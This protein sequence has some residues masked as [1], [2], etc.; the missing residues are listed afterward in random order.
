MIAIIFA[1][2]QP[3]RDTF[4]VEEE[5]TP[6]DTFAEFAPKPTASNAAAATPAMAPITTVAFA[7]ESALL[8]TYC[9]G[10]TVPNWVGDHHAH[11]VGICSSYLKAKG[12]RTSTAKMFDCPAESSSVNPRPCMSICLGAWASHQSQRSR[13]QQ[14]TCTY[15][16]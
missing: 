15:C 7:L 2:V 14:P 3:S 12:K 8:A 1:T 13:V 5:G 11:G 16:V 4:R 6:A 10:C 9:L